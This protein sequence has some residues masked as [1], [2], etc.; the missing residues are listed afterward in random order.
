MVREGGVNGLLLDFEVFVGRVLVAVDLHVGYVSFFG[1]WRD[2]S[3]LLDLQ[4]KKLQLA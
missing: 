3:R 2:S 4:S 1:C